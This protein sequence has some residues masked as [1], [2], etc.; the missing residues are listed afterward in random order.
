MASVR[1]TF[2]VLRQKLQVIAGCQIF[3]VH[4]TSGRPGA[5]LNNPDFQDKARQG[6]IPIGY[7]VIYPQDLD[8]PDRFHDL[9]RNLTPPKLGG[10]DWG[11]WRIKINPRAGTY[12]YGRGGFFLHGGMFPGSAGC[13]DLGGGI[14]GNHRTNRVRDVI[15]SS[16]WDIE[17]EVRP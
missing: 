12:A 7:Y 9:G 14:F 10:G 4:A 11:D 17:L 16:S 3:E 15:K 1:M 6:P 8:D 13:I 2:F 5:T